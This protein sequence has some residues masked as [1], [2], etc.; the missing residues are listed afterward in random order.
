MRASVPM[1]GH[2]DPALVVDSL[3]HSYPVGSATVSILNAIRFQ[4]DSGETVALIGRSGSG[5][6]TLLNLISGLEPITQGDVRLH[7][8]S[9]SELDDKHR[10]LLR[11]KS[12][13]FIYQ[14]FNLIPTLSVSDNIALPM[15]LT[16]VSAKAMKKRLADLINDV[17]LG[18]RGDDFPDRLSGG[19]QQ[20]VAIARALAHAPKMILADEPTGN[21]D[22]DSGRQIMDLLTALVDDQGAAM[23]LVTHS[24]EVA[25][26]ANRILRLE[27]ASIEQIGLDQLSDNIAW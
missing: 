23:L 11:G 16:G 25:R 6:S 2:T 24:M 7:Q 21:L 1:S 8:H 9:M 18:G 14:S 26:R 15:A 4:V 27:N 17:G 5:K 13:G 3:S 10:T 12:L 22:A 20:R 19:E